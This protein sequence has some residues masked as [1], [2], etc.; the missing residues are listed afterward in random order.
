MLDDLKILS[1]DGF[2]LIR[3]YDSRENSAAV[4]ELIKTHKIPIRGLLGAWLSAEVNN[5]KYSEKPKPFTPEKLSSQKVGNK[6]C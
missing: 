5:P 3:I 1:K 4:L 6:L 2:R